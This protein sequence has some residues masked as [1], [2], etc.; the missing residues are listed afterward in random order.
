MRSRRWLLLVT[1]SVGPLLL[2]LVWV[3]TRASQA[4]APASAPAATGRPAMVLHDHVERVRLKSGEIAWELRGKRV[5]V[6]DSGDYLIHELTR[7]VYLSAGSPEVEIV[8][9]LARYEARSQNLG[10]RGNVQVR[11]KRG[12][13]F[14]AGAVYWFEA[15]GKMVAR[16]VSQLEWLDPATP[17]APPAQINTARL[18]YWPRQQRFELP[19]AVQA[20][21]AAHTLESASAEGDLA[22]VRLTLRG[23]ARLALLGSFELTGGR[24]GADKRVL[25]EVGPHGLLIINGRSGGL[26]VQRQVVVRVPGDR[27]EVRCE[28]AVYSGAAARRI[29]ASGGVRLSDPTTDLTA[30]E[31][32]IATSAKRADFRGPVSLQRRAPGSDTFELTAPWLV[33]RYPAGRRSASAGGRVRFRSGQASGAGDRAE[34]DLEGESAV[35][36]GRVTLR[37]TSRPGSGRNAAAE[38]PVDLQSERLEH[39]WQAGRRASLLTGSPRFRQTD[40]RGTAN[41]IGFDHERE[42]LDL[43]GNVRLSNKDGEKV[44]CVRLTYDLRTEEMSLEA[45]AAA[46]ILLRG[47]AAELGRR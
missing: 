3:Q 2:A 20:R 35:L 12:L 13:S 44:R 25:L 29:T 47:E 4:A 15:E 33:Y 18:F 8:A 26:L 36:R 30:P 46:E 34:L 10:V 22:Q 42:Q 38:R 17:A 40:R 37:Y 32:S 19:D 28:Q 14:R 27:V 11:A 9:D 43:S 7:G 41:R 45:P 31:V 5:D 21:Y 23:P 16:G 39:V 24:S 1:G 6:L